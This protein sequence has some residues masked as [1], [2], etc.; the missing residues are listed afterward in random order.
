MGIIRL[1]EKVSRIFSVLRLQSKPEVEYSGSMLMDNNQ[2][3]MALYG[4]LPAIISRSYRA[5][6]KTP[7]AKVGGVFSRRGPTGAAQTPTGFSR[8]GGVVGRPAASLSDDRLSGIETTPQK[9]TLR[10]FREFGSGALCLML[11]QGR[12][13]GRRA[14]RPGLGHYFTLPSAVAEKS[15]AVLLAMLFSSVAFFSL[16]LTIPEVGHEAE[17][18]ALDIHFCRTDFSEARRSGLD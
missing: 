5:A 9:P 6:H 8:P 11:A 17:S 18:H 14:K 10:R 4:G 12:E 16:Y 13:R 7:S 15:A 2:N 1:P 3:N